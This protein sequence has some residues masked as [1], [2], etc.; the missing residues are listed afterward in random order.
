M[1]ASR[2]LL[3]RR[4]LFVTGKG[5]VGKTTIAASLAR[6]AARDGRRV[7][8]CE[9]DAK[10]SLAA[11][12]EAGAFAFKPREVESGLFGM[13]MNTEDS[14]REYLRLFVRIPLVSRIGPLARMFDF[15]ADAAPGVKEILSIGKLCYEVRERHYDLVVVDAEASGHI[16]GQISAPSAINDLVHVG[17]VREQ[18]EWM[19]ELMQDSATTGLVVVTTPEEMPVT[20][21]IELVARVQ[22]E[23]EVDVAAVIANRVLPEPFGHGEE[24]VFE[25][26][27]D[28][29]RAVLVE[30]IGAGVATVLDSARL[31]V[32][33]RRTGAEHL[34]RLRDGL[35]KEMPVL[36]VPELFA[37]SGGRRAVELMAT[38]L[39]EELN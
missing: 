4:L 22:S 30:R 37:R 32:R 21:T 20:E 36:Y 24:E 33:L 25:R 39:S 13:S 9:M 3:D 14:L 12:F 35:P 6:L 16:V 5:G 1:N 2:S 26:I 34:G 11:A 19:L 18:T 10:G 27:D 23:T 38:A 8:V 17:L 15:V 29:G 28:L 31:A 7:L